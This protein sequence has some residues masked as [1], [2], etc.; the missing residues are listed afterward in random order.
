M[1]VLMAA[2]RAS[3]PT[4][5]GSLPRSLSRAGVNEAWITLQPLDSVEFELTGTTDGVQVKY[6]STMSDSVFFRDTRVLLGGSTS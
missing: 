1:E 2:A 3:V 5:H 4:E 6:R